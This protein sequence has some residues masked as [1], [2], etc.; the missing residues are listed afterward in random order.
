MT[1]L[2]VLILVGLAAGVFGGLRSGM[3]RQVLGFAGLIVA[4]LL[5]MQLMHTAGAMAV[6]SL[7]LS[8]EIAP[9][10]GFVLVFLVVQVAIFVLGRLL[11]AVIGALSLGLLNRLLGGGVGAFRAAVSLSILFIVLGF[12]QIPSEEARAESA[13][14]APVAT[15]LPAAWDYVA[16]A[17]P[18]VDSLTTDVG[19]QIQDRLPL[20]PPEA[21]DEP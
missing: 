2:D 14:Y 9:L 18:H 12:F 16:E 4:F 21:P 13:L 1:T 15:V 20:A 6:G 3:I 17:F 10:V 11:E 7:G 5:A 8:T 19:G